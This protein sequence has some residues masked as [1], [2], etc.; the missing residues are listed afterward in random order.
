MK[1]NEI[2]NKINEIFVEILDND[3]VNIEETTTAADIEGWDSL[4]NIQIIIDIE[5]KF[6]V[7]FSSIEIKSWNTIGEM[8][9]SIE[10][11]II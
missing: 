9:N 11:K 5:K 1:R 6:K 8:I 4:T 7:R 3:E 2:L 10:T